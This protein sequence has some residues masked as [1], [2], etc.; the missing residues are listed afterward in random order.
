MLHATD[1]ENKTL[2]FRKLANDLRKELLK[3]YTTQTPKAGRV[4]A[5]GAFGPSFADSDNTKQH[6]EDK[7][8]KTKGKGKSKRKMTTE[9][10]LAKCPACGFQGHTLLKCLYVFLEKANGTFRRR[11]D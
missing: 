4:V 7:Q 9:E 8:E 10:S 5:K 11:K 2:T 3:G 6:K 1:I